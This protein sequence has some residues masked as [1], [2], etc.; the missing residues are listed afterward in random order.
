MYHIQELLFPLKS[1]TDVHNI[2]IWNSTA[3]VAAKKEGE[4]CTDW[5]F[6]YK[7]TLSVDSGLLG[8]VCRQM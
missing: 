1:V 6:S 8:T 4:L 7:D 5:R 2:G 3:S